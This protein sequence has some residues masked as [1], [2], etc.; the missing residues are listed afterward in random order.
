MDYLK[1]ILIIVASCIA[2]G[3]GAAWLVD[4]AAKIARRLGISELVIGL[5][6]VAFGTSAPEF[7]ATISAALKGEEALAL[8]N[9][10]GSN[11]FNIGF[12]LGGC[13]MVAAIKIN[14]ALLW[15]DS[16]I[17]IIITTVLLAFMFD[18]ELSRLEGAILFI[19]LIAY[20]LFLFWKKQPPLD[21]E[22][23]TGTAGSKDVLLLILGLILI[24]AGGYFLVIAATSIAQRLGISELVIG[25]TVVAAGTSLPELVISLVAIIK[26][27]H[28][29]SA[30]NLVGSNLFN[31]LGVLGLAGVLRPISTDNHALI[32]IGLL[33]G[34][35]ALMM[36][37]M[38]TKWRLSR[39][40][41]A[42]L[43]L[44]S[45]AIW[46]YYFVGKQ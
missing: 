23:P 40:E 5:T 43:V 41:G 20:L 17:L 37:F 14:P 44:A 42:I 9:V 2:L 28:G 33:I 29:I 1:D 4:S 31:T 25:L 3:K 11:T 35:T 6:I 34:L 38:K 21:E 24:I 15:R 8:G 7:A 32:C 27:H 36:I 46:V 19:G 26:K 12:I 18:G 10:I 22:L 16:L 13:A 30:G 45:L 39:A